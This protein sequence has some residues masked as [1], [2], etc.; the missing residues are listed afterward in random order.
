MLCSL[1]VVLPLELQALTIFGLAAV[2]PAALL[3]LLLVPA[4]TRSQRN[5]N[6]RR[7]REAKALGHLNEIQLVHV[8]DGTKGVRGVG[9][10]IRAVTFLRGLGMKLVT[11]MIRNKATCVRMSMYLV[12]I[13]VLP[14]ELFQLRLNVHNLR[15]RELKLH[16]R[17][18]RLLEV[19]QEADLGRLEEHQTAAL[20][21]GTTGCSADTVNVVA[22]VIW[23]VEL[24]D[25]V[26]GGD[27]GEN[28]QFSLSKAGQESDKHQGHEQQRRYR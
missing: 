26:D 20:A 23:G 21:V 9:L 12:E 25:P 1:V 19:L 24:D 14:N 5:V 3:L 15:A 7:G 13:V 8:K 4:Q 27:L 16:H 2:R 10:E 18:T 6:P 28:G 22:R 11:C 17:H